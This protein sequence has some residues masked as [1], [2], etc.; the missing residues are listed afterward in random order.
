MRAG[1]AVTALAR[2]AV[3]DDLKILGPEDGFPMLPSY[4]I[5]V[6]KKQEGRTAAIDS[7]IAHV[8]R[9]FEDGTISP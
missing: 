5:G 2:C 1:L 8:I 3:P 6:L 4:P 9:C 7:F